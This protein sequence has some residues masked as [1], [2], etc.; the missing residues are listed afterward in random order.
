[1]AENR[2]GVR[3]KVLGFLFLISVVTYLDRINISVAG[4]PMSESFGLSDREF[5][6]I[7]SAFMIGYALFQIPAGWLGDRFGYRRVLTFVLA[8]WSVF[9]ALT[10]WAGTSFL[11]SLL[12]VVPAICVVR[13]LIGIGEAAAYP[14]SNALLGRWFPPQE[15]GKAAGVLFAGIG[16]GSTLTPPFIAWLMISFGWE[17]SFY[18][19]GALGLVLAFFFFT[20]V[21]DHPQRHPGISA[22]ELELLSDVSP[23]TELAADSE[24]ARTPWRQILSNSDVWLL[25]LSYTCVGYFVFVYF[26]WFFRYLTDERGFGEVG[27]SFLAIFPF[28]AVS[29][30]SPLGGF[31]S[32]RMVP[33]L[34]K[35]KSRRMVAMCGL[36]LGFPLVLLGGTTGND[37]VAVATLSLAL[38]LSGLSVS[39]YWATVV[40]IVP[41]HAATVGALMNMGT[42]LAGAVSPTLTPVIKEAYG[43]PTAWI[44]AGLFGLA[45]GIL[46]KF[47]GKVEEA[48]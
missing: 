39:S 32:D 1:M 37:Y 44:V 20:N 36:L 7:F 24:K 34:G 29:V 46:W 14:C 6:T 43:W 40:E 18:V 4:K 3:W 8:W 22:Q 16:V 10:A 48:A 23:A 21:T 12:G 38:G 26:S 41:S 33:R 19:C 13:F 15:R 47:V 25:T 2:S 35:A 31:L 30:T 27:G 45:A 11:A 42:N 28:L 9:T 5:G 17:M